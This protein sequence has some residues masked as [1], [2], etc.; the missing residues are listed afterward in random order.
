MQGVL[1]GTILLIA[2]V[3]LALILL[4]VAAKGWREVR[5]GWRRRRRGVLEPRIL[6]YAHGTEASVLAALGGG[7]A[8]RDRAVVASILLDHVQRVRGIERERLCRALDELG[9]VDGYLASL[10]SAR[11]WA[12]A[13]AA[14]NLG[15]AGARRATSNLVAALDDDVPEV[16]LRAAKALGLVGGKAAVLPLLKA[17][18]EPNRWSTIRIADFLADM[19]RDVVQELIEAFPKLNR[20]AK[21][22]ALDIV[23]RIHALDAVPWLLARLDDTEPDVRARAAH[24]LGAIGVVDAAPPL[25]AALSDP[26]WPVRAM[27]AKALGRIH[28]AEAIP[29]LCAALRDR[30]WWVRANAAESLKLVGPMGIEALEGMLADEDLYAKHQA[31]LMLD[32]SGILDRRVAQLAAGGALKDAA[33]AVVLAFVNAGQTGRLRELS[34]SHADPK[35]RAAL[36][37]LVPAWDDEEGAA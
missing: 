14:E 13:E 5:D 2:S 34:V 6:T 26:E 23:G 17:L 8:G 1:L 27:A 20:H 4:I 32:E 10:R 21:L 19:G 22:A 7:L 18:A 33:E 3:F 24:A 37:R 9:Y 16:G 36:A 11:W 31:C 12:R 15:L 35:V 29:P 30:E 28:D 25:R